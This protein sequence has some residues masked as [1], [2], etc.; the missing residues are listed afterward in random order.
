MKGYNLADING[1][2]KNTVRIYKYIYTYIYTGNGC[3][4]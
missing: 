2:E 1:E 3:V 4:C